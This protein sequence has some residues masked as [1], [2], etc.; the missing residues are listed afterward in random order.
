MRI[1]QTGVTLHDAE[2]STP[3]FT[4][5]SP[6]F[7]PV[8]YLIDMNGEVVHDWTLKSNQGCLAQLL[9]NGNLLVCEESGEVCSITHGRGGFMREYDWDSNLVWEHIDHT[10]HHDARRLPN[11]NTLYIGWELMT[12]DLAARVQGGRPGT[13][14]SDGGIWSDY[15]RVV[16]PDGET[17]W[18][19]HHWDE[20]IEK[21]PMPPMIPRDEWGHANSCFP[22]TNGDVLLSFQRLGMIAIVDRQTSRIKWELKLPLE[23]A[24]S[25]DAQV[26]ENGNILLFGNG[27]TMSPMHYSRILEYDP[28]GKD[29][30]WEYGS[31]RTFE[32]YS[33][34]MSGCQRLP[35]GN[36]L[37]CETLW[38]R[39]FEVTPEG[40]LVW[41]Y[42]CPF[43]TDREGYGPGNWMYRAYRYAADS[44]QIKNRV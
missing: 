38:G 24:S 6:V 32:F 21:Y 41:E 43:E 8:V 4:L 25:H 15:L 10:Q 12:D 19:W 9:E 17:V 36:T 30:V 7:Q 42:V 18:E 33:P 40:E 26:L 3:G 1:L 44:P 29:I 27:W 16:T 13:E 11:G 23:V 5:V 28:D 2:K 39:I 34:L 20:E 14:H 37:I 35:S 22:M 31:R